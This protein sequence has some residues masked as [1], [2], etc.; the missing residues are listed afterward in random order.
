MTEHELTRRLERHNTEIVAANASPVLG[1]GSARG[2][3]HRV[4]TALTPPALDNARAL[5]DHG[6]EL[7][8]VRVDLDMLRSAGFVAS[9]TPI[10]DARFDALLRRERK[11]L[12]AV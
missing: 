7:A 12:G 9:L 3:S 8:W 1:R 2:T 4:P 6:N 11:L 10:D 5:A